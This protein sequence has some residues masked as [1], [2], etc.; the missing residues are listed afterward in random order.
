MLAEGVGRAND[1]CIAMQAADEIISKRI[2]IVRT[3]TIR[4]KNKIGSGQRPNKEQRN[5]D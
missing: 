2:S 1:D 5:S 4:I 3:I